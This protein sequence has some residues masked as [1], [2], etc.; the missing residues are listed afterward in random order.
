MYQMDAPKI[1][2]LKEKNGGKFLLYITGI[3]CSPWWYL[4]DIFLKILQ[5]YFIVYEQNL[6]Y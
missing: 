6:R 5:E 2:V 3:V 1:M 4:S